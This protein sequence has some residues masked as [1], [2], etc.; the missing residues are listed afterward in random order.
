M[1]DNIAL[2]K[3]VMKTQTVDVMHSS[4][5][6]GAQ[7]AGNFG[8]ASAESFAARQSMEERRKFVRGYHNSRIIGG[9][10]VGGPHAKV[11]TPPVR[12]AGPP[13]PPMRGR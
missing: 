1:A 10:A 11:Y 3:R 9:A 2:L 5:Y 6:A 8:A 12:E 13:T 7:N 4:G